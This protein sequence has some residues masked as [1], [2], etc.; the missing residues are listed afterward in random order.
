MKINLQVLFEDEHI[1]AINKPH[2]LFVHRT[3]LDPAAIDFVLQILR[4]QIGQKVYATHRLD[5]KTSGVLL[6]TKT[7]EAH[8]PVNELFQT[9]S[10]SKKYLAIVRGYCDDQGSI[11]YPLVNDKGKT[12]EAMT[13]YQTLDR[14]DVPVAFGKFETSRYS[15]VSLMPETGRMHQLRKHMSHIFHPIIGDRPHG[16]NKQNKLFLEHF[17]MDTML[18]HASEIKFLHPLTG[19]NI[20]INAPIFSEFARMLIELGFS[21]DMFTNHTN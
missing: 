5:R 18:L 12:Q 8:A 1:I 3:R 20:M 15:L 2:G 7:K 4:D 6:L 17:K 13:F 9:K 10:V 21:Y 11:D 14:V 16:C 19:A